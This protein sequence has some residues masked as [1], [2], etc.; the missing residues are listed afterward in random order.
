MIVIRDGKPVKC[1]AGAYMFTWYGDKVV[2]FPTHL[3]TVHFEA[4]Q[5]TQEMMG[6][7]VSGALLWSPHRMD[8]GPFKLYKSFGDE[9]M[10]ENSN[11]INEKL[12]NM[13]ISVIRD[14]V[15]NLTINAILRDRNQLRDGIK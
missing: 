15:A 6:V 2:K 4:E 8:N 3:K 12:Q 13:A 7:R 14:K 5:V 1:G 9:L 10:Y 11:S